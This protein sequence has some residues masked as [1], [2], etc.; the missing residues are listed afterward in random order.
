[1]NFK[2]ELEI[3]LKSR[4]PIVYV[5]TYEEERLECFFKDLVYESEDYN[6][7]FSWDYINGFQ[8]NPN[9][10]G[11]ASRNPLQAL[12]FVE[13]FN[14]NC[15]T[16]FL[17]KDYNVFLRDTSITRKL[18]NF[19]SNSS[20]YN[21]NI[22]I[23]ASEFNVPVSL[24]E[25]VVVLTF[26][27][28]N[29]SEIY[30]E[31]SRILG[32][33]NKS[34]DDILLNRLARSCR[35]LSLER[36]RR[37]L[38]K[39][40]LTFKQLDSSILDTILDEKKQ[41]I[42]Q[43]NV[44]EF[45]TQDVTLSDI[46]GLD[47]LKDWLRLRSN[48]FSE[49]ALIYGLPSPKG[50]LLVGFQGTGKSLSAKVVANEWRLPLLRLDIGKL[51]GGVVGESESRVRHMIQIAESLSPC[52]L[53]IDEIDKGFVGLKGTGDSGTSSRVFAT[54]ITWLSEKKSQ[55]FVVAT[56]NEI[57]SLPSELLRKGRFD[58]IF[59]INLPSYNERISIFS[60]H[61]S[62]LR[63]N[64][65]SYYNIN[66]MSSISQGFSGAEIQ[67]C[68]FEAMYKAF[69][70]KR[71]F[72]T[73]DICEAIVNMVPLAKTHAEAMQTMQDWASTGKIRS[74]SSF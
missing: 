45:C 4:H 39:T 61:L 30:S 37:V 67:Q 68:I 21:K 34:L 13:N 32:V 64:T 62:K 16:L 11:Y 20:I 3:V 63:P 48:S 22:I 40:L 59:F 66:K 72:F 14:S 38:F 70:E 25:N 8:G 56:A 54:F 28:P 17:L 36:V 46:G 44:L 53:W 47:R 18:R 24:Q 15:S 10:S 55:V 41:I 6:C 26:P 71:E 42:A 19:V 5:I 57:E 43:T 7:C 35:G 33:F 73:D 60:V 69:S 23:V 52:V 31:I 12:E 51:F 74:A 58:E 29:I 49:Q 1:M 9:N 27:L 2:K 65:W 50:L